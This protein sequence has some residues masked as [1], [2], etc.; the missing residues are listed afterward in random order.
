M[1]KHDPRKSPLNNRGYSLIELLITLSILAIVIS[2]ALPGWQQLLTTVRRT[3]ATT[4]LTR[5]AT[6]QEQFHLQQQRYAVTDELP[7]SFP[8]GLG[9]AATDG[10]HY[11]LASTSLN[12]GFSATATVMTNGM[13]KN[14]ARCWVFGINATGQRWAET[15]TGVDSTLHCWK[16]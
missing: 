9:L 2:Y 1:N 14:D 11:E 3:D 6:R 13:Q 15:Y 16:S 10:G 7:L 5:L 4:A 12:N 8:A